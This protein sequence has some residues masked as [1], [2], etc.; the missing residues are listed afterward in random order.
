MPEKKY[1][2]L[3]DY[4]AP[5]YQQACVSLE[6][7][8]SPR[9]TT[10]KSKFFFKPN[11]GRHSD[12]VLCGEDIRLNYLKING[13][14][15]ENKKVIFKRGLLIIPQELLGS[16]DFYLEMEND[17]NPETNKSLEG[18]YL[19]DGVLVTQCEAEGFR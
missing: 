19:S 16:G 15:I 14:K 17:L 6:F 7:F 4:S 10:L 9:L 12:L 2:W 18:L 3:K 1:T 8:L 5:T 13:R 11:K